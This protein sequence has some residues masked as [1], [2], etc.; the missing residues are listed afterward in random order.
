MSKI[1]AAISIVFL[2]GLARP[3]P[4]PQS[5]Q[6][7]SPHACQPRSP[8]DA[9]AYYKGLQ[10]AEQGVR[11]AVQS[12]R[13][14]PVR[15]ATEAARRGDWGLIRGQ[16][17]LATVAYG[18][19]CSDGFDNRFDRPLTKALRSFSDVPDECKMPGA[20]ESCAI[21]ALIDRYAPVYNRALVS[22]PD[23]PY[24]DICRP[25]SA[26]EPVIAPV[27]VA[28][29]PKLTALGFRPLVDLHH[30]RTVAEAARRGDVPALGQ[31]SHARPR[32][33]DLADPYGMTPLAWAV[34]YRQ[35]AAAL[36]LVQHGATIS[37]SDCNALDVPTSPLRLALETGQTELAEAL[38][39]SLPAGERPRRWSRQLID[40]AA[41]GGADRLLERML[42][43]D[44]ESWS[45]PDGASPSTQAIL[46]RHAA[47]LCW[48]GT[49]SPHITV[50]LIAAYRGKQPSGG[51]YSGD[52]PRRITVTVSPRA[53]PR[54]IVLSAY[55]RTIWS[56]KVLPGAKIAGIIA[57][58][59]DLQTVVGTP[60]GTRLV[61]NSF[62][63]KCSLPT[64]TYGHEGPDLLALENSIADMIG[65]HID[66]R[67]AGYELGE[68]RL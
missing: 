31:L 49:V 68:V 64:L 51:E 60:A 58:G 50:N 39:K 32:D 65:H 43:E 34:S 13:A 52:V 4:A 20:A 36:W 1:V 3:D 5:A 66:H 63:E 27:G 11:H 7:I 59:Y 37:G 30:P 2:V 18:L 45:Q 38:Y 28:N 10:D 21:D 8:D 14:D 62:D 22:L 19:N 57:L 16:G 9:K 55:D 26:G 35:P 17:M 40:A 25:V 54:F 15:D 46:D 6:R 61:R 56:L 67:V 23:Y 24:R 47:S 42:R 41:L 12:A 53:K 33:I 44:H 29:A 48:P